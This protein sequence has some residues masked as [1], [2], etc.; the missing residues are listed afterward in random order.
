MCSRGRIISLA[1]VLTTPL[2]A[3]AGTSGESGPRA[4]PPQ[5]LSETGLYLAPGTQSVDPRNLPYS[6]QYPLWSDGAG[7]SR[8]IDLPAGATIDS[9]DPDSWEFPVG[10]KLWKEF[11]FAGRKVETRLI[12]RAS[13]AEWI[14]ASYVWNEDQSDAVLAPEEGIA[15]F[16]EIAPGKSHSIPGVLDCKT[17]HENGKTPILGFTALQLSTDRDPLAPHAEPLNE[18]MITLRTLVEKDLLHPPRDELLRDP[19]RIRSTSP[20][21]RAALGYF[22]TNCG[23]CHN[24]R[25]PLAYLGLDLDHSSAATTE[26]T[27][28]GIATTLGRHGRYA[29][30]GLG[31]GAT[32]RVLPGEPERSSIVFRM[33]SRRPSSQMPPL[34]SVLV[35]QDAVTLVTRWI[36]EDLASRH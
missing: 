17:C 26:D 36:A 8:W 19:P 16:L 22:S 35:D 34:G 3:P 1:I 18:D 23:V 24:S 2:L 11:R 15:D 21:T 5:R 31:P 6:P 29:I 13:R 28:A 32:M 12:I 7:K 9:S 27:E 30:P 10:T 25:G 33:R 20:R 14:F 4:R